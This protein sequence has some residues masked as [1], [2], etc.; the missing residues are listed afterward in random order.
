MNE[1]NITIFDRNI[2]YRRF[3][4]IIDEP[5]YRQKINNIM[6]IVET[7]IDLSSE[8]SRSKSLLGTSYTSTPFYLIFLIRNEFN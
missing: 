3:E 7:K 8:I 4:L 1:G 5:K 6:K 2:G